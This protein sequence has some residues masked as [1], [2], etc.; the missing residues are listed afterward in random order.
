MRRRNRKEGK[1]EKKCEKDSPL[2]KERTK[3]EEEKKKKKR[4]RACGEV[5]REKLK[6]RHS[7]A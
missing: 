4:K 3:S 2:I 7:A 5:K 6:N 1:N